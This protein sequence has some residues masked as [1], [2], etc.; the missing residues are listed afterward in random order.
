MASVQLDNLEVPVQTPPADEAPLLDAVARR[1]RV[2]VL[3]RPILPGGPTRLLSHFLGQIDDHLVIAPPQ[4]A[5]G[6]KV[7]LPK[8]WELGLSFELESVW[9]QGRT[10]VR[11]HMFFPLH[12]GRWVDGVL[13]PRPR[14]L[15][16]RTN[17]RVARQRLRRNQ[18]VIAELWTRGQA[19]DE[20]TPHSCGRVTDFTSDSL[21]IYLDQDIA[22]PAQ[23]ELVIRL[24]RPGDAQSLQLRAHL[25]HCTRQ[26]SG[27]WLLGL[28][29]VGEITPGQR[30]E[31]VRFLALT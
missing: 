20:L 9:V 27:A 10:A 30:P 23:T 24:Q 11:D 29:A 18:I 1:C 19:V 22:L 13:L 21:G 14:E 25:R 15:V 8:D 31:L 5:E 4:T 2:D 26:P 17:R 3:A 6:D 16:V 12:P 7:F 28:S